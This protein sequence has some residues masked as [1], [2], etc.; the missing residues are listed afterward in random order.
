MVDTFTPPPSVTVPVV[1][2]GPP[3][4]VRP[5]IEPEVATLVTEPPPVP[6]PIAVLKVAASRV[7]TVLSALI[8]RNVIA[9]GLV[10]V[11]RFEPTVVA[12]RLVRAAGAELAPVP[13][14]AT[15]RSVIPVIE[16]PVILTLFAACVDMVQSPR[17]VRALEAQE[18]PVPPSATARSVPSVSEGA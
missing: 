10:S 15:A 9:D 4:R 18:A 13:P 16:P 12:P 8:R 14:S 2:I 6:A 17:L 3:V 7:E 5:L 1:V 11:K